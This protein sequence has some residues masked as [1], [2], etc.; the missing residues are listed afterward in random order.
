MSHSGH[1]ETGFL[2]DGHRVSDL[3][4]VKKRQCGRGE[5]IFFGI[6]DF[7]GRYV[8]KWQGVSEGVWRY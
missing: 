6:F 7:F 5:K 8:Q 2:S 1:A 3:S 4:A